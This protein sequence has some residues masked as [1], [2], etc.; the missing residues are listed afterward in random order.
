MQEILQSAIIILHGQIIE[1]VYI[2]SNQ[3][4]SSWM[5]WSFPAL[6]GS[7]D[8]SLGNTRTLLL[9]RLWTLNW[10]YLDLVKERTGQK[11]ELEID[12]LDCL[13]CSLWSHSAAHTNTHTH[14][15]TQTHTLE[16]LLDIRNVAGLI[17]YHVHRTILTYNVA[18]Y[19]LNTDVLDIDAHKGKI[20]HVNGSTDKM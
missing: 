9:P 13:I 16:D 20:H 1:L 17:N 19:E 5:W 10:S 6:P 8:Q 2:F 4:F 7:S 12:G 11:G 3:V 15:H 18:L 14:R